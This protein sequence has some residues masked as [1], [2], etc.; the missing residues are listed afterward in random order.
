MRFRLPNMTQ[1]GGAQ[2]LAG[3]IGDVFRSIAMAPA[4]E[5]QAAQ[6]YQDAESSRMLRD[7]QRQKL[8]FDMQTAREKRTADATAAAAEA[9]RSS[10]G[11]LIA[12]AARIS[13]VPEA[14]VPDFSQYLQT[15][16]MPGRYGEQVDGLGA[17][18]QA[19]TDGVGPVQPVPGFYSDNTG[20][21]V[22]R[23]AGLAGQA[24]AI[25]D[26]S[27]EN[28]A[29]ASEIYNT[30]AL[31]DAVLSGERSAGDVGQ[32][33]AAVA[34]KPLIQ[35]IGDT[36][37]GFNQF[38]GAR[39]QLDPGLV[40]IFG[41]KA[42]AEVAAR[43]AQ[44]GASR[45]SAASSYASA[46]KS[47]AEMEQGAK[48]VLQQTDQG[49]VLVNPRT[50]TATPVTVNGQ[51]A[52]VPSKAPPGYRMLPGGT[53]EAIPGG[54]ADIKS[55]ELG[56]KKA[57]QKAAQMEQADRVINKID[58]TLQATSGWTA[59]AGGAAFGIV[60]GTPAR[61]LQADLET[62]KANLGFAELQAMRDASPTG[63]ALGAIAVQ[64]LIALQ[65]TV[66]S[67]DRAQSPKQ[68]RRNLGEVRRRY[69]NWRNTVR[70]AEAQGGG[71][72]AST[73]GATGTWGDAPA[74]GNGGWSIQRVQ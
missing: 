56:A 42:A 52:G 6:Q 29:K 67:L 19:P 31:R 70:E 15:G 44:A 21:R 59:G 5:M 25:G 33:Q 65:S 41:E 35:N 38:T 1:G 11:S 3:G 32:A 46:A 58:Q 26:K 7:A 36:G 14:Q 68:L 18:R 53:M 4:Y 27:T 23:Q 16:R 43:N 39:Q 9:E 49:L 47:R 24:L 64:E 74:G 40:A 71:T 17:V 69:D 57:L 45:A 61:N 63:G 13:G 60:P 73:G 55:G 20:A 51:A 2:S 54:P 50:A 10:I 66:A 8:E 34:G 12:N 30:Q 28:L 22:M 37:S 48:G 62:I 72:P